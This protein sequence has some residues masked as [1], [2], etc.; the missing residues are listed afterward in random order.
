MKNTK[1]IIGIVAIIAVLVI[2]WIVWK[3]SKETIRKP[4]TTTVQQPGILDTL[5]A[6]FEK[7]KD[8]TKTGTSEPFY[9]KI[10]PKLCK[11]RYCDCKNP[12][13]TMDGDISSLC[14]EGIGTRWTED[15]A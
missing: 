12:G 3:S 14:T 2:L 7:P 10:F 9:C 15:C 8:G 5:F 1:L 11:E 13:Y 6:L 4:G